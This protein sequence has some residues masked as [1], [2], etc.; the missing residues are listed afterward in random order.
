MTPERIRRARVRARRLSPPERDDG[1]DVAETVAGVVG[2]QAQDESAAALGVRAR[3]RN[4]TTVDVE[5]A[6]H[7]ERTVVR[8]WCLRGALHLVAA[9]DLGWLLSVFGPVFVARGRRRLADIG[10]DDKAAAD[11]V[12][13]IRYAL[14]DDGPLTREEITAVLVAATSASTRTARLP[15]TTSG[16]RGCSARC[17]RSLPSTGTR[18]ST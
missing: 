9:I 4:L 11:A 18:R 3:S 6:L 1:A 8:T 15:T 5:A 12:A 7:A 16:G 13:A 17:A 2:V 10:F 14:A